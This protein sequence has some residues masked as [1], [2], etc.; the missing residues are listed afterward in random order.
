[1]YKNLTLRDYKKLILPDNE[2][3]IFQ[4]QEKLIIPFD[5]KNR[6]YQEYLEWLAEGNQPE[7]IDLTND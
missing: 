3:N 1:M 5:E 4:E 7:V 6:H 2:I